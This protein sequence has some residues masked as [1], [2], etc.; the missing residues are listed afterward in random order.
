MNSLDPRAPVNQK[1][2]YLGEML[3]SPINVNIGL[4]SVITATVLSFPFGLAGAALPLIAFGAGEAIAALFIP[5]S[6]TFRD[7]VDR[8]HRVRQREARIAQLREEI[9]QRAGDEHDNWET[10]ARLRERVASVTELLRHRSTSLEA[11]EL[12]KLEDATADYLGLW[13]GELSMAERLESADVG[14]LQRRAADLGKK[15][16]GDD[17]DRRSLVKAKADL[18]ELIQRHRRL[19]SRKAA[20]DAALLSL[21][22]TVEEIYQTLI[23]TPAAGDARGQLQEA[24]ERLRLEE[25]LDTSYTVE[26]DQALPQR[27]VRAAAQTQKH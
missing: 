18:E 2:S 4:V 14:Q 20:V 5:S 15:I 12:E 22:D 27:V 13:L 10:F 21:P 6:P 24:I 9:L 11:H 1:P 8:R 17:A 7:R 16:A 26:L 19:A 25:E 23:T 3:T